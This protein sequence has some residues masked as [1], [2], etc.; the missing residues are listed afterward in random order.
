MAPHDLSFSKKKKIPHDLEIII[1]LEQ[2]RSQH[3]VKIL[4][5][6]TKLAET[7]DIKIINHTSMGITSRHR[8][9]WLQVGVRAGQSSSSTAS[10]LG[11]WE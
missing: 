3:R 9:C 6:I 1:R 11:R 4:F 7:L 8:A 10:F 2:T 5:N